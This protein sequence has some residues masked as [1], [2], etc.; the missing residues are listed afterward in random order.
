M[1]K[2]KTLKDLAFNMTYKDFKLF[3]LFL[4]DR[5]ENCK[6]EIDEKRKDALINVFP[7]FVMTDKLK[8]E[9]VKW[10]KDFEIGLEDARG[11]K[12]YELED[13]IWGIIGFIIKFFNI[14]EA[15][16]QEGK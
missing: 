8:S 6:K 14:T 11:M 15:D 2:L 4:K 5:E 9:A 16:L 1:T 12:L 7:I 13:K 3:T 10:V